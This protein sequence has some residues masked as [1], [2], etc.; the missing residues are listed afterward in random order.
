MTGMQQRLPAPGPVRRAVRR[1]RKTAKR[2]HAVFALVHLRLRNLLL[3]EP[4]TGSAPVVVC[5]TSYGRRVPCASVAIESIARG[6]VRPQRLVLWLDSPELFESRPESLR[7]LERRGLEI[8]LSDNFGPHTKYYPFVESTERHAMP[9]VTADD[10]I[11]YPPDWLEL[12]VEANRRHPEAVSGHWVNVMGVSGDRVAGYVTWARARDTAARP[13]N[14]A[15]GVSGVIYPPAMLG[16]LRQRG[17][18]FLSAC[19]GADDIWLQWVALRA[20]IPVRQVGRV[21]RHFPMIPGSQGQA[22]VKTNVG[23]NRNDRWIQGLYSAED[24]VAL[25]NKAARIR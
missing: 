20:G 21:P 24:V 7:R 14:M 22:L 23:E 13:A 25:G 12:L 1:A 9:L 4:V 3:R 16:E 5:L 17:D 18:A 11:I 15:L 2:L 8:R 10:D 19:P 6:T